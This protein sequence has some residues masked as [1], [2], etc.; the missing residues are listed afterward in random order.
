MAEL[1]GYLRKYLVFPSKW[2]T[3]AVALWVILTHLHDASEFSPLLII[4]SATRGSGKSRVLEALELFVLRPWKNLS[5]TDAVLFRKI[6][7][8]HPTLLVDEA[9]NTNWRER[10]ALVAILNGGFARSGAVVPR[11]VGEDW[12]PKDFS[13]WA[14]KA[15]ATKGLRGI[16]DTTLSR[17]VIVHMKRRLRSE[18]VAR[19]RE[20]VARK[21]SASLRAKVVRWAADHFADLANAEPAMPETIS[22][23]RRCLEPA[24]G[25]RRCTGG[26]LGRPGSG[27]GRKPERQRAAR[28]TWLNGSWPTFTPFSSPPTPTPARRCPR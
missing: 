1:I 11:C 28:R 21:E 22:S 8:D 13:V 17:A 12:E 2:A 16:P 26:G 4:T 24:R 19:F 25:Y 5:P 3:W 7:V 20:R 9:D 18:R 23:R 15:L 10:P 27:S 6:D 14:P